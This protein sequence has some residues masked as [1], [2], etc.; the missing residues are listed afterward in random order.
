MQDGR[1]TPMAMLPNRIDGAGQVSDT[2]AVLAE[3]WSSLVSGNTLVHLPVR[4]FGVRSQQHPPLME[5][6]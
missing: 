6:I 3:H 2:G 5:M 4:D 1:A